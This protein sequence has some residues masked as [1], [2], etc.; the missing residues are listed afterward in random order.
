MNCSVTV[1]GMRSEVLLRLPDEAGPNVPGNRLPLRTIL[2]RGIRVPLSCR[3]QGAGQ[4]LLVQTTGQQVPWILTREQEECRKDL[5]RSWAASGL[6][7]TG[8]NRPDGLRSQPD[9]SNGL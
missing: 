6:R 3:D 2:D 7:R 5:Y 4:G 9:A 8:P 1:A